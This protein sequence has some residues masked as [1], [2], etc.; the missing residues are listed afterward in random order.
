VSIYTPEFFAGRSP[1]VVASATVVAPL[2]KTLLAPGSLLDVGC[3]QGEWLDAFGLDDMLGVDIAAPEGDR[4]RRH[5]LAEPLHLNRTFDLVLCLEVGEHLPEAAADTLVD[6][7]TRHGTKVVF[8][9][10]VPGQAGKGHINCQPHEYWH[11]KFAERGFATYDLVRPLMQHDGR[12][13][14]WYRNNMFI[15]ERR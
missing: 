13:S 5:D 6:T 14:P 7:L 8:S 1:T 9:A 4:Y 3:G 15:H 12:V 10:A 11:G 2:L